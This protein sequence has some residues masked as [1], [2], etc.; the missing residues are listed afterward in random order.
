MRRDREQGGRRSF[1]QGKRLRQRWER[2]KIFCCLGIL[3]VA[4]HEGDVDVFENL[5]RCDA[6]NS[7][8]RFDEI[9]ALAAG[10]LTAERVGEVET[11]VEL[12][13]FD[14]ETRAV[15]DPAICSFHGAPTEFE[16]DIEK[17]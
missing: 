4:D 8:G 12:L 2:R 16:I 6:E 13:G 3:A 9:V 5:T 11:R 17:W 1:A 14:E 10:V 7:V 15:C